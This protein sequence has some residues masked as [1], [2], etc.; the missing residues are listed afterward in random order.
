MV[1]MELLDGG[2]QGHKVGR[3]ETLFVDLEVDGV[4]VPFVVWDGFSFVHKHGFVFGLGHVGIDVVQ[5]GLHFA[6]FHA[7]HDQGFHHLLFLRVGVVEEAGIGKGLD[8]VLLGQFGLGDRGSGGHPY[9]LLAFDV[10]AAEALDHGDAV[11]A[12]DGEHDLVWGHF[13]GIHEVQLAGVGDAFIE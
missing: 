11:L 4:V 12:H 3:F 10:G 8:L 13:L 5:K 9:V 1:D 7:V 6:H 2:V